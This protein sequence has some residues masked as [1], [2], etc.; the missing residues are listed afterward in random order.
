MEEQSLDQQ[1]D[2]NME[3]VKGPWWRLQGIF[4]EPSKT[5]EDINRKP[6]FLIP[7]ILTILIALVAPNLIGQFVDLED[8]L[9]AQIKQ[10]PQA[11]QLTAEQIEQQ[12]R[13]LVPILTYVSPIAG[14]ILMLFAF[15]GLFLLGVILAGGET[16]F[17]KI[18]GVVAHTLFFQTLV[19]SALMVLIYALSSDPGAVDMQN[20]L[21]SNLGHLVDSKESPALYKI[22]S[23]L[24][25]IVWYVIFLLG[26]GISK[27]SKKTSVKK[28][29]LIVATLYILY[30]LGGTAWTMIMS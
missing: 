23:S 29:F 9:I 30:V 25:V 20:P 6:G 21:F 1:H 10:A 7:L 22:A 5:F 13:F 24:D 4:F 17:G 18:L 27:V 19:G 15:S 26:L 11:E 14:P 16:T 2:T 3:P 28:G 12:A 8:L